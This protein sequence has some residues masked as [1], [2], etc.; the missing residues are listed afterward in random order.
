[1]AAISKM[2]WHRELNQYENH[3]DRE[4]GVGSLESHSSV[5]E[6]VFSFN[7]SV[8]PHSSSNVT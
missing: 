1:M 3:I 4:R 8:V 2:S 5:G 6:K 7:M